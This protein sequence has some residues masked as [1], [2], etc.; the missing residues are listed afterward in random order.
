MDTIR[1]DVNGEQSKAHKEKRITMLHKAKSLTGFTLG[2]LDG[3]I[4]KVKE[5]VFDDKL[6]TVR[7]LVAD[8]GNGFTD[9]QVLISPQAIDVVMRNDRRIIINLTKKQIEDTH[10]SEILKE[11]TQGLKGRDFLLRNTHD[12]RGHQIQ[13]ADG[14]V[15][16]VDDFIIDDEMWEIRCLVINTRNW[17][18]GK[19]VLV[20]SKWIERVSC[21]DRKD[22]VNLSCESIK[23][24][25]EYTE[26]S[27]IA[28]DYETGLHQ[29]YK[30]VKMGPT[31]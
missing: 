28:R 26:K 12:V 24:S 3:K 15:G 30:R 23:Q 16:H 10:D 14:K 5:F 1:R 11:W 17:W 19:K 2:C 18:P 20:S 25:P 22:F 9:R 6:W 8:I 31:R 27:L 4:G 13:A 29:Y 21:R 7:Y